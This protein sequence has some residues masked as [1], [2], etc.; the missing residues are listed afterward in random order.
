VQHGLQRH[1]ER[2]ENLGLLA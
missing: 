2:I 1:T